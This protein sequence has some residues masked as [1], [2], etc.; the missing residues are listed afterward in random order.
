M[1]K[2]V[3]VIDLGTNKISGATAQIEK[4]GAIDLLSVEEIDS[5]GIASGDIINI[6]KAVNSVASLMS[7][8]EHGKDRTVYVTTKGADIK[9]SL[10]RGMV[11]L[12]KV[13]R[14]IRDKDVK[15]A[16]G[17]ASMIKLPLERC[18]VDKLV[19]GFYI[20]GSLPSV[21]DPRGLY[22]MKL[23]VE[24]FVVTANQSK[25]QN[26]EKCIDH[27]GFLLNG[28]CLSGIATSFGVLEEKEKEKG[29]L[30][31]DVGDSITDVF[32]FKNNM[33]HDFKIIDIGAGSILKEDMRVDKERLNV[34]IEKIIEQVPQEEDLF[35]SLVIAGGG[36]LLEGVIEKTEK[37]FKMPTRIGI[38]KAA[39]RDLNS[40]D[41][42]IHT[43]TLG[44]IQHV[45]T[46]HKKVS[47]H[48]NPFVKTFQKVINLYESYF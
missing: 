37:S 7:K 24:A 36:A 35:S 4:S 3:T 29:V 33:L 32:I 28:V 12:G 22:G 40:Q 9:M 43:S 38:V 18:I 16:C 8:L 39:G 46:E 19:R 11:A 30:L 21:R 13:P 17:L 42:I 26:I 23:E 20:D 1:S 41:A 5:E 45:A 25:M 2:I 34:F 6:D 14:E 31:L 48:K 47:S 10:S 15:H 27:A 44:F